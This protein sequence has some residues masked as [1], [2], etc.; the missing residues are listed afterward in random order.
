MS[1]PSLKDLRLIAST[2]LLEMDDPMSL[3]L[4]ME[5]LG[6]LGLELAIN[7]GAKTVVDALF[8]HLSDVIHV[9]LLFSIAFFTLFHHFLMYSL[10]H[11]AVPRNCLF[12][13]LF[14]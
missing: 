3:N 1:R 11:L 9:G 13:L 8:R 10:H 7:R 2:F 5:M 12:Q 6:E 14:T 4:L